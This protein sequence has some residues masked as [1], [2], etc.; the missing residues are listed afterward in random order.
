MSKKPDEAQAAPPERRHPDDWA[1]DLGTDP[2][3]AAGA[4][5]LHRAWRSDDAAVTRE[6]F[7]AACAD[8]AAE[9]H[10]YP[11]PVPMSPT[12][13]NRGV[14]LPGPW[15]RRHGAAPSPRMPNVMPSRRRR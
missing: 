9:P 13:D 1:F 15:R 5:G 2:S 14:P 7:E 10:A 11:K 3:L 8:A 4:K 12:V 6:E